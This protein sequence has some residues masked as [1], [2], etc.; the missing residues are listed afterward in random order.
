MQTIK[1][2]LMSC[3][4][5]AQQQQDMTLSTTSVHCQRT[6]AISSAAKEI[7][8]Q[9]KC[10]DYLV[11]HFDGKIIQFRNGL[12]EDHLAIIFSSPNHFDSM[13]AAS[14]VIPDGSG[15]SQAAALHGVIN[16]WGVQDAIVAQVF[17][18]TA[19]NTGKQKGAAS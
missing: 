18:T 7:K 11:I 2:P 8:S 17:D 5:S 6:D 1:H 19:S 13:F 14:P 4:T 16:S 3:S 12:T 15:A 9:F 10:P